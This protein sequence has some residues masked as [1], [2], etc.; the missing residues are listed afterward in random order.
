MDKKTYTQQEMREKVPKRTN[1]KSL[2][3]LMIASTLT[4]ISVHFHRFLMTIKLISNT[5][6]HMAVLI[7]PKGVKYFVSMRNA[8]IEWRRMMQKIRQLLSNWKRFR[9]I[10]WTIS[11]WKHCLACHILTRK[12]DSIWN[13]KKEISKCCLKDLNSSM[14]PNMLIEENAIGPY[15]IT[16]DEREIL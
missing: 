1:W 2:Y 9:R 16:V 10:R 4:N 6:P 12:K 14:R 11:F 13:L 15:G 5:I 7:H 3:R 8:F